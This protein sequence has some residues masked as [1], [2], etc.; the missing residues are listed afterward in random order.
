MTQTNNRVIYWSQ[1]MS[2]IGEFHIATTVNGL[3]FIGS[4][5]KSIQELKNRA[6]Q[7]FL[8]YELVKD[9]KKLQPYI[10]QLDEYFRGKRRAFT[11]DRKSVV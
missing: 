9:D 6:K 2:E 5:N 7:R 8:K 3:C 4:P 1:Y 10:Q 11:I